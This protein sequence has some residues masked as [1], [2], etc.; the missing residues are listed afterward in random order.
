MHEEAKPRTGPFSK[1]SPNWPSSQPQMTNS[2]VSQC[3][4][5]GIAPYRDVEFRSFMIETLIG[6][7]RY[8]AGFA[9]GISFELK[10]F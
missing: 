8:V 4:P 10:E 5:C 9:R 1:S 3:T 6:D 2:A 7:G